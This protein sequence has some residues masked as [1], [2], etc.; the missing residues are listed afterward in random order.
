ME[1]TQDSAL[2]DLLSLFFSKEWQNWQRPSNPSCSRENWALLENTSESSHFLDPMSKN[3]HT[4][5]SHETCLGS[6]PLGWWIKQALWL[7]CPCTRAAKPSVLP[8]WDW[9]QTVSWEQSSME[10][11]MQTAPGP[12]LG[13]WHQAWPKAMSQRVLKIKQH[14]QQRV[15]AWDQ[16]LVLFQ[17]P[18]LFFFY[19]WSHSSL[20]ANAS[21]SSSHGSPARACQVFAST[22][23]WDTTGSG[24]GSRQ[25]QALG[26]AVTVKLLLVPWCS[27]ATI[28]SISVSQ[29]MENAFFSKAEHRAELGYWTQRVSFN[30]FCPE[31]LQ[32]PIQHS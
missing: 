3:L 11:S 32:S 16:A 19:Y 22:R 28:L 6:W 27:R 25:D 24:T 17:L 4:D 8:R 12:C 31:W 15:R 5:K 2:P 18:G 21:R 9:G 29:A 7:C 14:G 1:Q 30:H 13:G 26:L 20:S 23:H 10:E